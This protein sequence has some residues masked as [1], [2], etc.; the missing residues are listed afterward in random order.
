[1][2]EIRLLW[3]ERGEA[4]Q[5]LSLSGIVA[6][7]VA[8]ADAEGV[9]ALSMQR[10]GTELGCTA[11]ALYRHVPGK[12]QL[13]DLMIDSA[14]GR[15][16]EPG[17]GG[18]RSEIERWAEALWQVYLRHPWLTKTPA[19][20]PPVG[21]NSLAWFEALLRP[22]ASCGLEPEAMVG[23]AVFID[24]SIRNLSRVAGELQPSGSGYEQVLRQVVTAERFPT[25]DGLLRDGV[26]A[27]DDG[28]VK[29]V[30]DLGLSLLLDGLDNLL[31][32]TAQ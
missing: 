14:V 8:I 23:L 17:D 22:L 24:G 6:A 32:G 7:G 9:E 4:R 28:D 30:A 3:A 20:G 16:P 12:S 29:P 21:P 13:L 26:F 5:G 27:E 2:D 25:L 18:W 15:P 11:M 31:K 10:I 1:M 19:T